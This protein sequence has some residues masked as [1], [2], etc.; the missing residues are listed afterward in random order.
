M[1]NT[2]ISL[3]SDVIGADNKSNAFV[4]GAYSFLSKISIGFLLSHLVQ[5]Y[6]K[7]ITA[8]KY[9]LALVPSLS[10]L[11]CATFTGIGITFYRDRITKLTDSVEKFDDT[12]EIKR[13]QGLL[14]DDKEGSRP[15]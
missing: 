9:I 2:S 15:S 13:S 6:S 1:T 4:Y 5:I 14:N 8:I 3:I 11:G 12:K 7:D 10:A